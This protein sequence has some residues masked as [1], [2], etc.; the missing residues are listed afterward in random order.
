MVDALLGQLDRDREHSSYWM[1]R[2]G[3]LDA[4]ESWLRS[5]GDWLDAAADLPSAV[6]VPPGPCESRAPTAQGAGAAIQFCEL[7]SGH[8]GRHEAPIDSIGFSHLKTTWT[9]AP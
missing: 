6:V 4:A 2:P 3:D 8:A 9:D 1:D 5:L 7:R